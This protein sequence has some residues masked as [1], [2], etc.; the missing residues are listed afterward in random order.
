[1]YIL[2]TQKE[3]L[4]W[5]V[6][7]LNN[8]G[9]KNNG[10][11]EYVSSKGYNIGRTVYYTQLSIV[12]FIKVLRRIFYTPKKNYAIPKLLNRKA[13]IP[14]SGSFLN[15]FFNAYSAESKAFSS[16][17]LKEDDSTSLNTSLFT[18]T[19]FILL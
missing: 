12:P 7:L 18:N 19:D 4:E 14:L 13:F 16:I 17:Y 1:M 5:K 9:I 15:A 3:F 6:K 8:F 2:L 10:V 11:K